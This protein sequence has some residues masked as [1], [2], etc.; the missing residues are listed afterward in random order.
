VTVANKSVLEW[1]MQAGLKATNEA[2]K[3]FRSKC[4][5]P[6][7]SITVAAGHLPCVWPPLCTVP[8]LWGISGE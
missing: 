2:L 7:G 1:E 4:E 8:S 5:A 6:R 3:R